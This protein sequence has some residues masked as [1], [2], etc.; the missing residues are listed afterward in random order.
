MRPLFIG[1]RAWK[2]WTTVCTK[3]TAV[4]GKKWPWTAVQA[5]WTA[6][7]GLKVA[8]DGRLLV[9]DGP[10]PAL[11]GHPPVLD[12]HLLSLADFPIF[13]ASKNPSYPKWN[14][15]QSTRDLIKS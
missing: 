3:R 7:H 13:N 11:D 15:E 2:R 1:I 4:Q 10:L 12:G 6:I 14:L 8:M 9:M 5:K